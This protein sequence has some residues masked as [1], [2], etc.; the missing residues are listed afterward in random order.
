MMT[1]NHGTFREA[2]GRI[3]TCKTISM[4]VVSSSSVPRPHRFLIN[5]WPLIQIAHY[6]DGSPSSREAEILISPE[7]VDTPSYL[8]HRGKN[9][10]ADEGH[11]LSCSGG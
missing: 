6:P 10:G 8:Y 3:G 5:P 2:S 9:S 11:C 1:R 4:F 7:A